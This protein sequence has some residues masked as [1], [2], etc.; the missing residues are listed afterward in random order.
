MKIKVGSTVKCAV[1]GADT[2]VPPD[3]LQFR[4]RGG[5]GCLDCYRKRAKRELAR[6]NREK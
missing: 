1:C 3:H 2:D 5:I 6:M 4:V